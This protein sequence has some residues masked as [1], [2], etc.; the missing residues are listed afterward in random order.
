MAGL[1]EGSERH[2]TLGGLIL[3]APAAL[4]PLTQ[5]T[6]VRS[7]GPFWGCQSFQQEMVLRLRLGETNFTV[8]G[9]IQLLL[10][11]LW[12]KTSH[13]ETGKWPVSQ[14]GSAMSCEGT[15][16]HGWWDSKAPSLARPGESAKAVLSRRNDQSQQC[17][18]PNP[19]G[20]NPL[21][22]LAQWPKLTYVTRQILTVLN[23]HGVKCPQPQPHTHVN[24]E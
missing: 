17:W 11:T 15:Q 14:T 21:E 9:K 23:I 8:Q 7:K 3:T 5:S 2:Q 18:Q 6:R 10:E 1:C 16:G 22:C 24:T 12:G 20:A 4:P 13:A 19:P